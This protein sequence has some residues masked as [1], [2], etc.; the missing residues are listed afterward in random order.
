MTRARKAL[1]WFAG[2]VLGVLLGV[3]LLAAFGLGAIVRAEINRRGAELTQTRVDL[4]LAEISP[5]DGTGTLTGLT[6]G[7]PKGWSAPDAFRLKKIHVDLA[8]RSL[9]SHEIVINEISIEEPELTYETK[10]VASNLG[11]LIKNIK[12]ATDRRPK[13]AADSAAPGRTFVI[14]K[15]RLQQ[16]HLKFGVGPTAVTLDMPAV[17]F[18]NLGTAGHGLTS[19]ELSLYVMRII[20]TSVVK[21]TTGTVG[22][23]V[24]GL[25]TAAGLVLQGSFDVL[26]ALIP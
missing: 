8:P 24:T 19:D 17:E 2:V 3:Y 6:V 10:L 7:N 15:L 22:K 13:S 21:T 9:L 14:R 20:T 11:D 18:S 16:G 25:T 1:L 23:G 26:K 5:F 4:S 12:K